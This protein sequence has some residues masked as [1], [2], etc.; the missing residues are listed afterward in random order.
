MVTEA[1]EK[2]RERQHGED[3]SS[4]FTATYLDRHVH[5]TTRPSVFGRGKCPRKHGVHESHSTWLS[6]ERCARRAV[7]YTPGVSYPT[8][9]VW[10]VTAQRMCVTDLTTATD[11]HCFRFLSLQQ[12]RR[13]KRPR[14]QRQVSSSSSGGAIDPLLRLTSA[15]VVRTHSSIVRSP[16]TETEFRLPSAG[17]M[18]MNSSS[19]G[20]VVLRRQSSSGP[21]TGSRS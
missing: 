6:S 11:S 16:S 20:D 4:V 17:V 21:R 18:R 1:V 19:S 2:L 9:R 12:S 5:A 14:L 10:I 15:G 7:W 8:L 13:S 3:A